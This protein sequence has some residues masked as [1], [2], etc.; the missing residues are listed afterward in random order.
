MNR[1]GFLKGLGGIFAAGVAPAVV[2][3]DILMPVRKL[4]VPDDDLTFY[5]QP[6][7]IDQVRNPMWRGQLG[8]WNG[9]R[10]IQRRRLRDDEVDMYSL[11]PGPAPRFDSVNYGVIAFDAV[12]R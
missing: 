2:G 3:S 10:I 1:R 8:V 9:V 4:V 5:E 6:I 11:V 7:W 12:H